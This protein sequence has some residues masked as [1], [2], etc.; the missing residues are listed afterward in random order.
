MMKGLNVVK[1][2]VDKSIIV[3]SDKK[4][5]FSLIWLHGLG[6]TSEG[7]LDFFSLEQSPVFMGGR[8]KLLQAPLRPV[9]INGG[10]KFPSWYDIKSMT[11]TGAEENL[12]SISEIKETLKIIDGHV[13]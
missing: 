1:N 10:A 2:K 4:P 5:L 9:S 13:E 11:F 6:D 8:V 12:F 3:T 7:F